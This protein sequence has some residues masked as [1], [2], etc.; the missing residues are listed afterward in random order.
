MILLKN[1]SFKRGNRTILNDISLKLIKGEIF[2][3]VGPSGAGKSTLLQIIAGVLESD[4]GAVFLGKEK[5]LGPSQR[6][7]PGH[8]EVQLVNQEFGL[9]NY[10][11]VVDNL[12]VK[13]NHLNEKLKIEIIDELLELLELTHLSNIQAVH[14]SGGEK[15]R[16]ALARALIMESKVVLLDEP[17]AHLDA[18]IKR[19]VVD[20]LIRLKKARKTT[21][22]FVTHDGQ[23]VLTYADRVGYFNDANFLRVDTPSAFYLK[24]NSV[25]EAKFFGD[26]NQLLVNKTKFMFRPTHFSLEPHG[27]Y[28]IEI[29]VIFKDKFFA[30]PF[31]IFTF[32]VGTKSTITLYDLKD[33]SY[34]DKIYIEKN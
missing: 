21:F 31:S 17:F 30:G 27:K 26:I 34:V 10:H 25:T 12:R 11:S 22:I 33:I 32:K 20:Y 4:S 13:A 5:L 14:L 18:H 19:R 16:L 1:I 2:G 6:L 28:E 24:P 9:D 23:D 29:N 7:I 15:Q 8:P 3:I